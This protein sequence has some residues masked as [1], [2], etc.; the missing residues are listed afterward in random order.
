MAIARRLRLIA[1]LNAE[2]RL[3]AYVRLSDARA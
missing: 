1:E 3:I 2:L